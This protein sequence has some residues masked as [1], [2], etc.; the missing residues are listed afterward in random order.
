MKVAL[1][2]A[3]VFW[4]LSSVPI[5]ALIGRYLERHQPPQYLYRRDDFFEFED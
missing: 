3:L 1:V 2:H 5:A 4:I